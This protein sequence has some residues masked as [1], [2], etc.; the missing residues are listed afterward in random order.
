MI[1][2]VGLPGTGKSTFRA[3]LTEV[4]SLDFTSISSD[5][6]IEEEARRA[7]S[8]YDKVF[9]V[10]VGPAS[11]KIRVDA[12]RAFAH[13]LN[14]VWDQTNLTIGKRKQILDKFPNYVKIC[15]DF[16]TPDEAIWLKR[17]YLR[18][19]QGKYIPYHVLQSMANS[20]EPITISEG[21]DIIG[22]PEEVMNILKVTYPNA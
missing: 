11:G 3:A 5:D 8:T 9:T 15:V 18:V 2:L 22:S 13:K 10:A 14:V 16:E 7:G 1:V 17:L 21:F 19:E 6:Y 20:F 4:T 12:E